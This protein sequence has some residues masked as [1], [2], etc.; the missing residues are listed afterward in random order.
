[1]KTAVETSWAYRRL[2]IWEPNAING[3]V[4]LAPG[5]TGVMKVMSKSDAYTAGET[6][7]CRSPNVTHPRFN[8][9]DA[10]FE[11]NFK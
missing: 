3:M 2:V 7:S 6:V 11:F 1:M 10:A 5:F 8:W 9:T 4:V